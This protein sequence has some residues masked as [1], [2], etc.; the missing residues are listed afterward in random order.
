MDNQSES[1]IGPK[2]S[3]VGEVVAGGP[4]L[5]AGSC[6]GSLT[7]H[8][9]KIESGGVVVGSIQAGEID[10]AGH[11]EGEIVSTAL[12]L[13]QGGEQ[14]GRVETARLRLE[15]GAVVDF[16]RPSQYPPEGS[17][18]VAPRRPVARA[19]IRLKQL[20]GA[21]R[22]GV[23]PCCTEIPCSGRAELLRQ[24]FDLLV[25]DKPLI[26]VCGEAGSG[27]SVLAARLC[28][29]APAGSAFLRLSGRPG[30]VADLLADIAALLRAAGGHDSPHPT[31]SDD[32][33]SLKGRLAAVRS[34]LVGC[35]TAGT[36]V[37][38][39][40]DAAEQLY[41]ATMEGLINQLTA[42]HQSHQQQLQMVL[43]GRPE[44][45]ASMVPTTL[46]YFVDETNCQLELLPLTLQE[47]ADYLRLS[48]RN[49]AGNTTAQV[50]DDAAS[51][52]PYESIR[53]IHRLSCGNP[54]E[55]NRLADEL[56]HRAWRAGASELLPRF[57]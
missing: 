21:F 5:V 27:K 4:V 46:E 55:I 16:A 14:V 17:R 34:I 7:C 29:E 12:I 8:D 3:I 30:S 49:A 44:M 38:V 41:P 1:R 31:T 28:R 24:L 19:P 25:R 52:L 22:E 32:P 37:V 20:V 9:L 15:P 54:A 51:L 40:V 53:T 11:L 57:L 36:R 18:V 23:R 56:L 33:E 10:C 35:R 50:A 39:L 42:T 47:T 13:R 48:L 6:R 43:L 45:L 2:M 26:R